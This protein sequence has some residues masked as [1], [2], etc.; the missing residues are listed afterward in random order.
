M[1]EFI[2]P[3]DRP[4]CTYKMDPTELF[5]VIRA[6]ESAKRL[7]LVSRIYAACTEHSDRQLAFLSYKSRPSRSEFKLDIGLQS[8]DAERLGSRTDS[9]CLDSKFNHILQANASRIIRKVLANVLL[10]QIYV[11]IAATV[12]H[13]YINRCYPLPAI[14]YNAIRKICADQSILISF[15]YMINTASIVLFL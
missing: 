6:R 5:Y 13:W 9:N 15:S 3:E 2:G 14:A 8:K 11:F 1:L 4:L 7:W 10:N 12:F